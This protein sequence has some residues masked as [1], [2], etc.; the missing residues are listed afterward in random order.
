MWTG[1]NTIL[2]RAGVPKE[3]LV[4]ASKV[5]SNFSIPPNGMVIVLDDS[6]YGDFHNQAWNKNMAFHANIRLGGVE[7]MSPLHLLELMDTG[8]YEH[9]V[10]LSKR[11]C[12]SFRMDFVW[13]LS[14][15][16][17]H[18][19][20]NRLS[21]MLSLTQDFL[22]Q[23]LGLVEIDEPRLATIIP[24]ELDAELAAWCATRQ[25]FGDMIAD[26]YVREKAGQDLR[27]A[28]LLDYKPEKHFDFIGA[29]VHLLQK[30]KTQLQ[31]VQ[32]DSDDPLVKDFDIDAICPHLLLHK[33]DPGIV[34]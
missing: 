2:N 3:L 34:P 15:E 16:L 26:S 21:H 5:L 8:E 25:L 22:Y 7:E 12:M 17:R 1:E 33:E 23:T 14:H 24:T 27:F 6:D 32:H 31:N 4:L 29:T 18:L 28:V 19:E 11:A 13:I 10:W 9:L 30:Y 20:H